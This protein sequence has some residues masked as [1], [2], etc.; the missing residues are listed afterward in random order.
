V[1]FRRSTGD[2]RRRGNRKAH[3]LA[4]DLPHSDDCFCGGISGRDNRSLSGRPSW[5]PSLYFGG[6]RSGAW[7][8]YD[9]TSRSRW[10]RSWAARNGNGRVLL[11]VTEC[12][13]SFARSSSAPAAKVKRNDKGKVE[14][15]AGFTQG[16]TSWSGFHACRVGKKLNAHPGTTVLQRRERRLARTHREPSASASSADRAAL[17]P[18]PAACYE[19]CE[20]ISARVQFAVAGP[21]SAPTTTRWPTEYGHRQ[22]WVK[23]YVH[24]VVIASAGEVIARHQRSYEREAVVF[25]P[26]H[27]LALLEQK[28]RA[29][30][31]AA[32]LAGWQLPGCFAQLRRLL[33]A[34]LSKHGSREYV[35]V[36]RLAWK[37]SIWPS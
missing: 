14:G 7:I 9:N 15:L 33:E 36:L 1:D 25:D 8:L 19:A 26:L 35:Q 27:Y 20:K 4:M 32:P 31:Q 13:I 29:L 30:D 24:E 2:D 28:T 12:T 6:S 11:R 16:G 5:G 17:L 22:V 21:L 37:P 23:G 10:R 3:Y 34:R 18:L